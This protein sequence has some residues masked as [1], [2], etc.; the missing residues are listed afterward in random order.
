MQNPFM[1]AAH[2]LFADDEAGHP[3]LQHIAQHVRPQTLS[4]KQN[5]AH[6][7][8]MHCGDAGDALIPD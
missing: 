8:G 6:L 5:T 4:R 7:Q 1:I 2:A 3:P